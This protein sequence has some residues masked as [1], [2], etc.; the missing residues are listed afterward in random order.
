MYMYGMEFCHGIR[1]ALFGMGIHIL[2]IHIGYTSYQ[3]S[4][5]VSVVCS[6]KS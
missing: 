3:N 2:H 4:F 6:E 5:T 1:C